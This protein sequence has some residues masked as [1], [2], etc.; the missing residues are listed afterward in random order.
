MNVAILTVGDELLAGETS[1]SNATWLARQ[2]SDRGCAVRRI[3]TVPDDRDVVARYVREWS[4]SFDAVVVTGGLGGTPD[5][6][7]I[8]AVAAGLD[9]DLAVDDAVRSQLEANSKQFAEE[10]PEI[11]ETYDFDVDFDAAASLPQG[12][13][14][15]FNDVGWGPGC[16]VENVYCLPG[17]PEEMEATFEL[18]ADEFGGETTA[19]TLYTPAPEGALNGLLERAGERFDV[20]IG[21]YPSPLDEPAR[22]KITGE[23]P[24]AVAEAVDWLRDRIEVVDPPEDTDP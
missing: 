8:E 15:V 11:V 10:N 3:L 12:S 9:R 6:V 23:D 18:V 16:V 7:T 24:D 4:E 19:T 21:S 20:R 14:A 13:R 17:I 22:V 5:D 2:L 1:N